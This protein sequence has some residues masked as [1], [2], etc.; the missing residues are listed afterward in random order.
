MYLL[1]RWLGRG[2]C[3]SH[4]SVKCPTSVETLETTVE[5]L[6]RVRSRIISGLPAV[7]PKLN[8]WG[9][10]SITHEHSFIVRDVLENQQKARSD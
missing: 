4:R 1:P 2:P 8:L 6:S 3:T 9:S 5:V 10:V 7:K